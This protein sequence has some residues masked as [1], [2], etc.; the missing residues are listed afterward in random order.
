MKPVTINV[1]HSPNI[2]NPSAHA[3]Q[4]EV[5]KALD[6]GKR[7]VLLRCGRKFGKTKLLIGWLFEM[8]LKTGLVCPYIAPNKVQAK[9]ICWD[10]HIQILLNHFKAIGLPYKTN[11]VEL[12]VSLPNGGKVQLL[13]VENADS[14]RG[15]SNW[16]AVAGDEYDDWE[17]DIWPL[18]I[19]PNLAPHQA[20]AILAG[21]P[22]GMKNIYRLQESGLFTCFHFTSYENP[23]LEPEELKALETEYKSM[24]EAYYRQEILAQYER[25]VGTV[26]EEWSTDHYKKV[27]YD[28]FLPVHLSIDFGVN[29]PTAIIWL[30]PNGNEFR[31][32]DYYE[33][34]E[35]SVDH[36]AQVIRSK[37]YKKPE[38][39]TGDAAGKARSITTNTSPID[40]YAK[41]NFHIRTKD[42]LQIPDQVRITHKYIPSLYL[43]DN[44]AERLRDC[45]LNYA[46]PKKKDS[47]VNQ[48]NEIPVHD[49]WS[50]G[51]RALEYYFANIDSSGIL[52]NEHINMKFHNK[53][54]KKKWGIAGGNTIQPG[55]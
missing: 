33:A 21:T 6:D 34:S 22:H 25:P 46:Y 29:D 44:K 26:Y 48:S 35:A 47:A 14:L 20:P 13:G 16:G 41:H 31:V 8:A 49:Q 24:G 28:P 11:E 23:T 45:L 55:R 1:F 17:E 15:A 3:K 7:W 10:D 4:K 5:L 53:S 37:P 38:L 39:I 2:K 40:E 9:N 43:D 50:H 52:K 12:S 51:A 42:G 19:R 32:I 27:D 54:M 30:Q 36:F 18:I